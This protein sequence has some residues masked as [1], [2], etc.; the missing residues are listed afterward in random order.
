[1]ITISKEIELASGY[2]L[3]KLG[4]LN[5]LIFFDI[6]TTGFTPNSSSLYLIGVVYHQSGS[7]Q[8][9]QWFADSMAAEQELLTSFFD[10]I[11]KYK[12]LVHF[13]GDSFDIPYL[14]KCAAQYGI[15]PTFDQIQSFD[16]YRKVRPLRRILG[17]E[18]LKQKSIETPY[19]KKCA[20][21]YG[22]SPTFDQI[23]SF[24]IY[25]KVRPLRRILG[26]E[27]LKQKSIETFLG[28]ERFDQFNGGQLIEFYKEYLITKDDKLYQFLLLHN[29]EDLKGMPQILSILD[30]TD[31]LQSQWTIEKHDYDKEASRLMIET[32]STVSVPV[33]F[34]FANTQYQLHVENNILHFSIPVYETEL[35]Y[36][37]EN[38]HD[39]YY[40][41]DEDMAIH[42][43]VAQYVDK[44]HRVQATASNCYTKRHGLFLPGV[45]RDLFP[46]FKS[47]ADSKIYY[48]EYLDDIDFL[49]AYLH[50]MVLSL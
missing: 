39:Y 26:L 29:E 37:Y 41:P 36:F 28:L 32:V 50:Q 10:F 46:V 7:W 8:L 13:N 2:E 1:M 43:R 31:I 4:P 17:L 45:D 20:A 25:R 27:N 3:S 42:K 11:T 30:Y 24:D 19:L 23:Q 18:N 15:S 21:Q 40:L 44:D 16:I 48:H 6:E 9:K 47:E 34:Q 12:I 35:K 38:Y 33:P 22:I 49:N 5:E 14:K